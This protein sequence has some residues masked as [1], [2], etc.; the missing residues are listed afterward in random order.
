MIYNSYGIDDIHAF[1]VVGTRKETAEP[2]LAQ[3]IGDDYATGA[4]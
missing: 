2:K 4:V 3:A 1:G